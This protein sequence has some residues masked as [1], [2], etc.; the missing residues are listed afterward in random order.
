MRISCMFVGDA[1][2]ILK[3]STETN[4]LFVCVCVCVWTFS[5]EVKVASLDLWACIFSWRSSILDFFFWY[6]L[7]HVESSF[8]SRI[9]QS[10]GVMLIIP[11]WATKLWYD[12]GSALWSTV[13]TCFDMVITV[14]QCLVPSLGFVLTSCWCLLCTESQN[15]C[16]ALTVP[17]IPIWVCTRVHSF[18]VVL[19]WTNRSNML[20]TACC[21]DHYVARQG[22]FRSWQRYLAGE[23]WGANCIVVRWRQA[24]RIQL[25]GTCV[26]VFWHRC[27]K[28]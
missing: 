7:W 25:C 1:G 6:A 12:E 16:M 11:S 9:R 5:K 13:C 10:R 28:N 18:Q 26:Q 20:N 2:R 27:N 23:L 3:V 8:A 22:P 24:K 21:H 19:F 17:N 15:S 4:V 14:K